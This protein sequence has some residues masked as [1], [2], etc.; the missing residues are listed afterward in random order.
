MASCPDHH[1]DVAANLPAGLHFYAAGKGEPAIHEV[2]NLGKE[3]EVISLNLAG[4]PEDILVEI[5]RVADRIRTLRN[6][7]GTGFVA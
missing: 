5:A 4:L 1:L 7:T 2:V 6:R 3:L